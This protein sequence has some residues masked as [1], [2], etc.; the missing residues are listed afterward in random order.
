MLSLSVVRSAK[1]YARLWLMRISPRPQS[2]SSPYS[3]SLRNRK[4]RRPLIRSLSLHQVL[5]PRSLRC[6]LVDNNASRRTRSHTR[7]RRGG[8]RYGYGR[9]LRRAHRAPT[10]SSPS[11]SPSPRSAPTPTSPIPM[12]RPTSPSHTSFHRNPRQLRRL[13]PPPRILVVRVQYIR[14]R[15]VPAPQ[16]HPACLGR[17]GSRDV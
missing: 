10:P 4:S 16:F 17:E 7:T 15:H 1:R 12:P 2:R 3:R 9:R 13:Q 5:F 6:S 14:A 11:P 8:G